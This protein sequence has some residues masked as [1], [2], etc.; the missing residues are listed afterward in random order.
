MKRSVLV[1]ALLLVP[2][3]IWA[4][5]K[6][7]DVDSSTPPSFVKRCEVIPLVGQFSSTTGTYT[8]VVQWKTLVATKLLYFGCACQTHTSSPATLTAD[9]LDDSVSVL[10]ALADLSGTV[11]TVNDG[12]LDTS[13][14]SVAAGSVMSIDLSITTGGGAKTADNITCQVCYRSLVGSGPS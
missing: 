13:K 6:D 3:L 5:I 4:G 2:V 7:S 12:T 10:S 1:I 11:A 14:T 8:A 9:L